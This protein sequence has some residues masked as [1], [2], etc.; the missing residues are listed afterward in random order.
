MLQVAIDPLSIDKIIPQLSQSVTNYHYGRRIE[1]KESIASG[2]IK[3]L[4]FDGKRKATLCAYTTNIRFCKQ[5][6]FTDERVC[7]LYFTEV[8]SNTPYDMCLNG[9]TFNLPAGKRQMIYLLR[10]NDT[11]EL[12]GHEGIRFKTFKIMLDAETLLENPEFSGINSNTLTHYFELGLLRLGLVPFNEKFN[13]LVNIIANTEDNI[14]YM[15]ATE[16]IIDTITSYFFKKLS[17]KMQQLQ[18]A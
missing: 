3:E 18:T 1:L 10:H 17:F 9:E 14:F 2:Y 11:V 16:K 15:A 4:R 6:R 12:S 7:I 5:S 13:D 8:T